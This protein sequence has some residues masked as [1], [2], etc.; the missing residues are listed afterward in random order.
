[1]KRY[2]DEA[3]S[4][5][6]RT[7]LAEATPVSA[8]FSEVEIAS[9]LARRCREGAFP[10]AERDR[11]IAQLREDFRGLTLV[12][13]TPTVVTK[14]VALLVRRPLRALDALQL[15]SCLELQER[16]ASSVRFIAFDERLNAAARAEGL[17]TD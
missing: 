3:D 2:V 16:L 4:E 15:A 13:T 9:A 12:E 10:P 14:A 1:V 8:R 17:V 7:L 11:A 6:V 5:P